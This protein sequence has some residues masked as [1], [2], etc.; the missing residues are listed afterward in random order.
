MRFS[1]QTPDDKLTN[2]GMPTES[3]FYRFLGNFLD[4]FRPIL[5]VFRLVGRTL[6]F[7]SS[8]TENPALPHIFFGTQP[9]HQIALHLHDVVEGRHSGS[10]WGGKW[11]VRGERRRGSS[12]VTF[13]EAANPGNRQTIQVAPQT[14]KIILKEWTIGGSWKGL[15]LRVWG[16]EQVLVFSGVGWRG[17]GRASQIL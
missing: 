11:S 9:H 15:S 3:N 17:L 7:W 5:P 2:I 13:N 14:P 1:K 8:L 10:D 4:T 6:G 12:R 16:A